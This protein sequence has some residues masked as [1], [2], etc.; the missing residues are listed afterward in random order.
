M[1]T[2]TTAVEASLLMFVWTGPG[3]VITS[4][5]RMTI[6]PTSSV[7]N[8]YSSILRFD[9]L[10]ETDGGNYSCTVHLFNVNDSNSVEIET[11]DCE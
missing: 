1:A 5:G 3:G 6:Q 7:G 4:N 2:T 10:T 11:P 9:Y 8:M